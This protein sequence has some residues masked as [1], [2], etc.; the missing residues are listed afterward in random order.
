VKFTSARRVS[1]SMAIPILKPK[2]I[3][4]MVII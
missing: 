2:K 4:M 1:H 3:S